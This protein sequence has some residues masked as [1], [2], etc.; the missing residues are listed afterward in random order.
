MRNLAT[1]QTIIA[2][3]PIQ[4][5]DRIE[6]ATIL[7]W[8]T[9]VEKG[10]FKVGDTVIYCE[11]DSILPIHPAF[12]FL[13]QQCY[14]PKYNGF[15]IRTMKMG[16][17]YSQ[18]IV[19]SL[20]VLNHFSKKT[21]TKIGTDV[22]DI[23][24]IRKYDPEFTIEVVKQK[25]NR[26]LQFLFKFSIIR[27]LFLPKKESKGWPIW[28]PKTDEI[29]IQNVPNILNEFKDLKV[30]VT[31]KMDGQSATY[32][33][34]D[35]KFYVC[36]RNI[37]H[38]TQHPCSY[39]NIAIRYNIE[40]QLRLLLTRSGIMYKNLAIQGEICGPGIQGNKYGFPELKFFVFSIYDIDKHEYVGKEE[41]DRLMSHLT[42]D[43]VQ[44]LEYN[45]PISVIGTTVDECINTVKKLCNTSNGFTNEGL[46]IRSMD[47]KPYIDELGKQFSFKII[48]P[49]FLV[50]HY[51]A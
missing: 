9:I 28:L 36:S 16:N 18:G 40:K 51:D 45:I 35:D 37:H 47:G 6:L 34:K 42:L 12:E 8:K 41:F 15:R 17:A 32:A 31:M 11:I 4:N 38:K 24:Q 29:R 14:S 27:K 13:R 2:L 30:F 23:L 26:F 25:R 46:V 10:K 1:I 21:F 3:E 39:W 5:R 43:T 33:I 48:N 22:T 50:K 49:D 7:G 44:T 20:D 19:F